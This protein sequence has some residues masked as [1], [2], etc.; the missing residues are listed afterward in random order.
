MFQYL[1]KKQKEILGYIENYLKS[2]SYAPT[3]DEIRKR[4]KFRSYGTIQDYLKHLEDKGYIKRLAN[5]PRAIKLVSFEAP[6][7][8]GNLISLPLL[9]I[10]AAG[11][12]IEV[13]ADTETVEV[14]RQ[15][16]TRKPCF[17]LK[18]KGNSMIEDHIL[19]GDF[20]IVEKSDTANNGEVVVALIE[21]EQA[22]LKRFYR[23]KDQ[24]R[25]QPA[26]SEMNPIYVKDIAIQGKVVGLFRKID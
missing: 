15:L 17:V 4:F 7:E 16:V 5:Q 18:V 20:I 8:S 9:G 25:L 19:N 1:T 3:F 13:C 6:A 12:P 23:E 22:T 24:I 26:N 2:K 10:I 21:R 11:A 14:P